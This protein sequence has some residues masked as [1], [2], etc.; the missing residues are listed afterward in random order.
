MKLMLINPP[1]ELEI[2]FAVLDDYEVKARSNQPPL[3]LMY[4]YAY[5]SNRFDVIVLDMNAKE[6]K[7]VDI[8]S[9]LNLHKPDIVGITCV[10]SKWLTVKELAKRI[11]RYNKDIQVVVGGVNPSLYTYETLQCIDI[12]YVVRGFGQLPLESLCES[13]CAGRINNSI[14]NCFTRENYLTNLPGN[15]GFQ[16]LDLYPIPN[17]TILPITDYNLPYFPENPT[18]SILSSCGCPFSCNFCQGRT[19]KPVVLRNINN[20]VDEMDEIQKLGIKSVIFQDELFTLSTKRINEI[21]SLMIQR[22]IC[23]HW[24]VRA[25]GTPIDENSLALMRQ[26]GCFNIHMGLESGVPRLLKKMNKR[27]TKEQSIEA[28]RRINYAGI[29]SSASF[30]LGYPTETEAEIIETIDFASTVGLNNCQFYVV[31]PPPRTVMYKE[32]Q[33]NTGYQGDVFSDFM[34]TPEKVDLKNIIA[35]DIFS[36]SQMDEFLRLGFSKTKNLYQVKAKLNKETR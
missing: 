18:T 22:N 6:E 13:F 16:N 14:Q 3:S 23:L 10:V 17:R 25:R 26:A 2:S 32:W 20:V 9:Y 31:I 35:S 21:C 29:L 11:K 8:D 12:D 30:M 4:L 27:I 19:F 28:I 36:K 33:Q 24:S 15:F 1:K 7:I 34:M 5:L